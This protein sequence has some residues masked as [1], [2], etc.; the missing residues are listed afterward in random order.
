VF[1]I[2]GEMHAKPLAL[3]RFTRFI[4]DGKGKNRW[5]P[6]VDASDSLDRK[7][8]YHYDSAMPG[9]AVGSCYTMGFKIKTRSEGVFK[10][11]LGFLTDEV[12][13]SA[14]LTLRI[15]NR[16]RT[17]MVCRNHK[18]CRLRP[19]YRAERQDP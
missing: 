4:T 13:G 8:N 15:E 3:E 6:G 5:V 2:D 14:T 12:D 17:R 7:G 11:W 19:A 16:P 18:G 1:G 9:R 10:A